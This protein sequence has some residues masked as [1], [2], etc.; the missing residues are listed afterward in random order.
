MLHEKDEILKVA[1]VMSSKILKLQSMCKDGKLD[2]EMKCHHL[3][4]I[5]ALAR[6][7]TADL[8]DDNI[9]QIIT[10]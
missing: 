8:G 7:V 6:M 10:L 1:Q 2:D 9:V 5:A 3:D 4:D